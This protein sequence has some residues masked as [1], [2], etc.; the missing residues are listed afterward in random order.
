MTE[1][2]EI[3]VKPQPTV[4]TVL[5]IVTILALGISTYFAAN[6]LMGPMPGTSPSNPNA[7]G[8]NMEMG[9]LTKPWEELEKAAGLNKFS[10]D[11]FADPEEVDG[12][13]PDNLSNG[14]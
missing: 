4:Y 3:Q 2:R 14:A 11:Q 7:N 9:D 1:Q 10:K 8:Y 12:A 6:R 5:L 13:T